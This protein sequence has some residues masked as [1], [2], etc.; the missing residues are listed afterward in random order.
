MRFASQGSIA[1]THTSLTLRRGTPHMLRIAPRRIVAR[2]AIPIAIALALAAPPAFAVDP[3]P[4]TTQV[5]KKTTSFAGAPDAVQAQSLTAAQD[6]FDAD[7]AGD[8]SDAAAADGLNSTAAGASS[9]ASG[10]NASAFGY[11]SAALG[12]DS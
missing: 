4:D 1:R 3:S 6:Y 7:G 9:V 11:G 2:R 5:D 12:D 10:T 8:G